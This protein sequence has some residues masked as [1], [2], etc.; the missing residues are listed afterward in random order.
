[1]ASQHEV[2]IYLAYWFQLGKPVHISNGLMTQRPVPVLEG[3]QLSRAFKDCWKKI[4]AVGG[5]DCY[6]DGASETIEQLLSP[7]WEITDCAR[8]SIP[9]AMP[10]VMPVAKA[11]PCGDI[12]S[13][14]NDELPAPHM[15]INNKKHFSRL[16][17]RLNEHSLGGHQLSEKHD[18][19]SRTFIDSTKVNDSQA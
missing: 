3:A 1:M 19:T 11:C 15:P 2:Q 4:I 14:P 10:S 18:L 17:T 8:C 16:K 7:Q 12:D 13:W 6:L 9:T 5:R